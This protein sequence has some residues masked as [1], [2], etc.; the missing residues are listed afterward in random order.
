M[1]FDYDSWNRMQSIIYP[2]GEVVSYEYDLGG[3]L[4]SVTGQK[5]TEHF[6]YLA[7]AYYNLHGARITADLGNGTRTEYRYDAL[8]RLDSLTT[9]A[10]DGSPLQRLKYRYDGVGNIKGIQNSANAVNGLGGSY[11]NDYHGV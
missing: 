2:D 6:T 3:A 5:G 1:D 8:Q 9:L 4:Y 10:A 11:R 7:K